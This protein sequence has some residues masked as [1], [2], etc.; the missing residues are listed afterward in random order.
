[1]GDRIDGCR[2]GGPNILLTAGPDQPHWKVLSD[3][4]KVLQRQISVASTAINYAG[5]S[6]G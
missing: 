6:V 2:G 3:I 5:D 1:M 4:S